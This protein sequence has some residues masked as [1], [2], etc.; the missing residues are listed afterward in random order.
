MTGLRTAL[1]DYLTMRRA[2][3][4]GL[5]RDEKLLA[6]FISYLE[7]HGKDTVTVADTLDWV[8]LAVDAARGGSLSSFLCKSRSI[9]LVDLV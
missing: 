1:G 9:R 5:V 8:Q 3:G 6:Q 2:L 4:L 7:V